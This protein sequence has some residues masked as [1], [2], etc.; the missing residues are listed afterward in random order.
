IFDSEWS[1]AGRKRRDRTRAQSGPQRLCGPTQL[2]GAVR[3]G[4]IGAAPGIG[5]GQRPAPCGP[6]PLLFRSQ[7]FALRGTVRAR[8]V[9]GDTVDGVVVTTDSARV[10][11]V[12]RAGRS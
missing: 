11:Q 1:V 10:A 4:W 2:F 3:R 7:S 12:A 6:F 8:L 5:S 9:P